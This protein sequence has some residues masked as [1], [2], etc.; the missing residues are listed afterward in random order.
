[1]AASH[2][3]Q[4]GIG[5]SGLGD[6]AGCEIAGVPLND[7]LQPGPGAAGLEEDDPSIGGA[8]D[9]DDA[10]RGVLHTASPEFLK[11]FSPAIAYDD[12]IRDAGSDLA[13]SLIVSRAVFVRF[14]RPR[15]RWSSLSWP[16]RC[17]PPGCHSS[18]PPGR[19]PSGSPG[20]P[21]LGRSR[22]LSPL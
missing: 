20:F 12:I 10:L 21:P 2:R 4:H 7:V 15:R 3:R 11:Q 14:L 1:L 22:F 13:R 5:N 19:R 6:A 17:C 18:W 9:A 16:G 8:P